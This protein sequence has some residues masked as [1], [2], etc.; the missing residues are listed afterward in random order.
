[1]DKLRWG[2]EPIETL[3]QL[4]RSGVPHQLSCTGLWTQ[5]FLKCVLMSH[6]SCHGFLHIPWHHQFWFKA[7]KI[8]LSIRSRGWK[9]PQWK[10]AHQSSW[11]ITLTILICRGLSLQ[12]EGKLPLY[13]FDFPPT[14]LPVFSTEP[15]LKAV[16]E[17]KLL[18]AFQICFF[19]CE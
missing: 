17:R 6:L 14:H 15:E 11:I 4:S 8:H 3:Y 10:D 9:D 12:R 13:V 1:M 18:F 2:F 16:P 19:F 7:Y 5:Y